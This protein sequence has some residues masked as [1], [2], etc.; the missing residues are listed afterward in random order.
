MKITP[1]L[2]RKYSHLWHGRLHRIF[3][4]YPTN[5]TIFGKIL[6]KIQRAFWF[7]PQSLF[8]IRNSIRNFKK[9]SARY[10]TV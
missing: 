10:H 9:N 4:L 7:S 8:Q 1:I 5:G 6:P 3:P 2:R